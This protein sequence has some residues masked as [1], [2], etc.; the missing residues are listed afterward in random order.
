MKVQPH[1]IGHSII[2]QRPRCRRVQVDGILNGELDRQA[3]ARAS[4]SLDDPR[5]WAAAERKAVVIE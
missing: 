3:I 4:I 1:L 5:L 2:S